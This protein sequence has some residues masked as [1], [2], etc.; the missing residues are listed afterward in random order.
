[1]ILN[2]ISKAARMTIDVHVSYFCDSKFREMIHIIL[3]YI[4]ISNEKS[5]RVA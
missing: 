5:A 3:S 4:K 1:M 2:N